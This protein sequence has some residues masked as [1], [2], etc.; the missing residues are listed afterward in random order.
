MSS[1]H[2][3]LTYFKLDNESIIFPWTR[4][5]EIR[6]TYLIKLHVRESFVH[7]CCCKE[8]TF[9]QKCRIKII[10][11]DNK[12]YFETILSNFLILLTWCNIASINAYQAPHRRRKPPWSAVFA[13]SRVTL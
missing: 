9:N 1:F 4:G 13:H 7:F 2:F 6:K 3:A 10:Q 12:V 11:N 8:R 5:V